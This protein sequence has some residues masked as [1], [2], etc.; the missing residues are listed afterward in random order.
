M[1]ITKRRI[2][3]RAVLRGA[4]VSL[5]LPFLDAMVPA[6][7]PL[8]M[9][10]ASRKTRLVAIEMVHGAAGSTA[11]GR[12]KNY[13]SPALEG[14]DFPFT[15]TLKSLEPLRDYITVISNTDLRN[16]MSLVPEEDGP[17]ADHARS[18]AVFLTGAHPQR[19]EGP[20][21]SAGPSIDQIYA[22]R[23]G[24]ETPI[25]SLQLCI[26]DNLLAGDCGHGYSCMYTHTISWA[27][28]TE[29]LPMERAPRAVFERLFASPEAGK[30]KASRQSRN[31][32]ILDAVPDAVALLRKRL[33]PSDRNRFAEYLDEIR[34][35]EKRIQKVEAS[36]S[37]GQHRELPD[38]PASVPDSFEEHVK[39]MFDLQ[40]LAFMTDITRVSSFKMGV[41]RSPRIYPESG[42]TTPFHALSHHR[43]DP[44][45]IEQYAKLNAYHVSK[46]AYFLERLRSTLDGDGNL[47]DH[48]VVLYGSPMG[49]SHVHEHKFLPL[50]LAGRANGALKGNLHVQCAEG[51]P[52]A[53]VLLTLMHKLGVPIDRIGDSTAEVGI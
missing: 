18:S 41:D 43:E 32:S 42:V 34:D 12:A 44:D 51:T 15:Q 21:V 49:D 48:S 1:F 30:E 3:R 16:A 40:I 7:T 11:I 26:E 20:D 17:M 28:P 31:A 13:W 23:V 4:S 9:T 2:S 36:N 5:A 53:N 50:F 38:A 47:L 39:L 6:M 45:K 24:Q 22:H 37:T 25:A 27:S 19:T 35:V 46:T 33:D 29:P 14:H 8:K 52:T 10:A